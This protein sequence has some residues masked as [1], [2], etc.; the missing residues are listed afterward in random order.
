M[1]LDWNVG[2][3][4]K[5]VAE[6]TR[7]SQELLQRI[8]PITVNYVTDL[9]CGPGNSTELLYNA[10]PNV[11]KIIGID[12]SAAMV[13]EAQ[14]RLP[15]CQFIKENINQWNFDGIKQDIIFANAS[16][17]WLSDH[18]NLFPKFISHLNDKGVLA[19]QMPN[20]FDEPIH[21]LMGKVAAQP[22]W[23]ITRTSAYKRPL[24][25]ETY[26]DILS[27]SGCS[28][29]DIWQT[30]YYHI[31]PSTNSIVDWV[32]STILR[33]F[34]ENLTNEESEEFV[35]EYSKEI[36]NAYPQRKDGK[37]LFPMPRLFIIAQKH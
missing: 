30:T 5:Y 29:I 32:R 19:I 21:T 12:S 10:W 14:K 4:C 27:S 15:S 8:P 37:I 24:S 35:K 23:N 20:N 16:L 7:P 13:E 1:K 25:A 34:V 18:E 11:K 26:Y 33:S 17:H 6:R 22:K 31:M 3:Y 28:F 9:G 36:S 2:V